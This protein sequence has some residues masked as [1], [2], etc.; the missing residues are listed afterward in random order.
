MI[1][2][3]AIH[4]AMKI[5]G[6]ISESELSLIYDLCDQ[7]VKPNGFV[8]ETGTF[9]GRTAYVIAAA[10]E[11]RDGKL[12]TIDNYGTI[13]GEARPEYNGYA[14]SETTTNLLRFSNIEIIPSHFLVDSLLE[15]IKGNYDLVFL[16]GDHRFWNILMELEVCKYWCNNIAGHD[17]HDERVK[18]AV[19]KMIDTKQFEL[20]KVNPTEQGLWQLRKL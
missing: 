15:H 19:Q 10:I 9:L 13:D 4:K 17:W 18:N 3:D 11:E 8:L 14:L 5:R 6:L 7:F 16:D 2:S 12:I 1:K 20:V